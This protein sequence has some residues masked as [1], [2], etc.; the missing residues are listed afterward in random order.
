MGVL[1]GNGLGVLAL[2]EFFFA[3][4]LGMAALMKVVFLEWV[5]VEL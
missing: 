5:R 3:G 4:D 1:A 2:T